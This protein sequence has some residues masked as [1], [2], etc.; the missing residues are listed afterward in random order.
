MMSK[1]TLTER[2]TINSNNAERNEPI[3]SYGQMSDYV[4][5]GFN[6]IID[7][8]SHNG[9]IN[10][11]IVKNYISGVILRLGYGDDISSQDDKE[12]LYNISE[13]ERLGIPWGAYLYSYAKST[14]SA[15]S[16]ARHAIRLLQGHHP[17]LPIYFDS[18][19]KG[20]ESVARK[21]YGVFKEM[22]NHAGYEVD[23]YASE[24]W[25]NSH[26][27]GEGIA[28]WIAK[29][30]KNNGQKN[31][32][33]NVADAW[34]WQYTSN[35]S[36]N[37]I[38]GRVDMNTIVGVNP[39]PYVQPTNNNRPVESTPSKIDIY[40]SVFANGKWLP[41]V[42]NTTDYAGIQNVPIKGIKMRVTNGS[43][44][45]RV[46]LKGRGWLPYVTGCD[47]NDKHNGFAGTLTNDID[48]IEAYYSTPSDYTLH[49][50][51]KSVI[52][53]VSTLKTDGYYTKQIDNSKK[54]GMDGYAGW[55]GKSI[56][57]VKMY[58]G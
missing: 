51:Y 32:K 53:Q 28:K 15:Q 26:L 47:A 9:H 12:W 33:P 30:G 17:S 25:Y 4:P 11:E 27:K 48:A 58:I 24:S 38:K 2:L 14:L 40:Y 20:T 8:S 57:C 35:G 13:V 50:G 46:H 54:N 6:D 29:Y 7:V 19:E 45:Y 18:E 21:N 56:D 37:G 31:N 44:K 3:S 43:I 5:L 42:K 55:L 1:L 39:V 10:W 23:I 52:Y 22:L 34:L 41:E 36:V 49:Y 16:E